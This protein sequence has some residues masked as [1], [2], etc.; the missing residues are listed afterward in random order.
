MNL[1]TKNLS[2]IAFLFIVFA[3]IAGGVVQHVLSCQMQKFLRDS[4]SIKHI[5]SIILIFFFI[6][7]EGGW[8]FDKEELD[9]APNDW[10]SGNV[11][12]TMAYAF[13]IYAVFILTSRSRILPNLIV[14]TLLFVIYLINTQRNFWHAREEI[15][16]KS[17]KLTIKCELFLLVITIIVAI[18]GFTDYVNYKRQNLGKRFSWLRFLFNTK[19]CAFDGIRE[20]KILNY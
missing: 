17:N 12:H 14:Y 8:D 10:A 18:Y 20:S 7:L 13:M 19:E 6:M 5:I 11:I 16:E 15:T 1:I 4:E 9:K 2:K 3:V